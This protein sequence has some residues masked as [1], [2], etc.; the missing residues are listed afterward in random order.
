MNWEDISENAGYWMEFLGTFG[1]TVH[2]NNREVKGY[3]L[4]EGREDCR[5]YLTSSDLREFASALIEVADWLDKRAEQGN[6]G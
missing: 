3:M 5:T 2:V 1:P 4:T 6:K